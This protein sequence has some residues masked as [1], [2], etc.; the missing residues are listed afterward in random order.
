MHSRRQAYRTVSVEKGFPATLPI[1][2]VAKINRS[3]GAGLTGA[4]EQLEASI[5][6]LLARPHQRGRRVDH[7]ADAQV[8]IRRCLADSAPA[9]L[10]HK[11]P[12]DIG[13]GIIAG[14]GV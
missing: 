7:L 10:T 11:R 6:T 14:P 13:R 8:C 4:V 12:R 5:V 1:R 3:G 9:E 2:T